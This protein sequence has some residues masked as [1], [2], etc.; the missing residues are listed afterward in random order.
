LNNQQIV[1]QFQ[2]NLTEVKQRIADAAQRSR[3]VADDVQLIAVS[4]Y[5]DASMTELLIEAGANVLGEN[6]PQ[7]LN[8]KYQAI[9]NPNVKWHLI[10]HLQR[11]KVKK[12]LPQAALIHSVDSIRLIDAIAK[13]AADQGRV[14]EVLL[15]ANVS[16]E[17]AKHGFAPEAVAAAL[18]HSDS[19]PAVKVTGLMCMAGLASDTDNVRSEFARLRELRDEIGSA[20]LVHLSMGMSGDFEIAIEEGATLVRVGSTLFDGVSYEK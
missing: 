2:K 20:D 18:D 1:Q 15:E 14:A 16:G 9:D 8:E 12:V 5:V 17:A 10:G 13:A 11:N 7:A 3:R 4:K 6:R 19:L